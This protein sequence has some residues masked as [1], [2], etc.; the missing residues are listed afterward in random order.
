EYEEHTSPSVYVAFD[1]VGEKKTS[2]AIWTTTPWTLPANLAICAHPTFEY[3]YY[4]LKDRTVIVAKGLLLKFL[5]ECAPDELKTKD[6]KVG[7]AEFSA[8]ALVDATRVLR[9]ASGEDLAKL[10]YKHALYDRTSPVLLGEHVTLD[11]GTGL[12]HTAP[13]HGQED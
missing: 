1:V 10:K 3:V 4:K 2:L 6:V 8:A 13:G 7:E 5:A 9:Y 11:A 12:V